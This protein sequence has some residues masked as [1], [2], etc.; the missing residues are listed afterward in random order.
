MKTTLTLTTP[1]QLFPSSRR[2]DQHPTY[3][4]SGSDC[5]IPSLGTRIRLNGITSQQF[6]SS[7]SKGWLRK[8]VHPSVRTNLRKATKLGVVVR[9]ANFDEHLVDGI[10][11]IF[12]ETPIRQGRRFTHYGKTRD[13]IRSEWQKDLD[14]SVFFASYHQDELIGFVK[15]TYTD[16]Y[17][18]MSGT[19]SKT[20]HRDKAP[21]S[22]MIA[23]CVKF[24]AAKGIPYLTYGKYEYGNKGPDSLSNF[25]RY[26]GFQ[27]KLV[28]RYFIPITTVG[29][30][31]LKLHLHHGLT[32]LLPTPTIRRLV[33]LRSRIYVHLAPRS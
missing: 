3:S 26:N 25:K 15:L 11:T 7:P 4:R 8:A 30:M 1:R 29:R 20:A 28:P 9:V 23:E 6:R 2:S 12:N 33:D 16:R 32:N 17:A 31:A 10:A 24:C 22:S 27:K 14:K 21:M 13:Q 5:P 19:L 18:E